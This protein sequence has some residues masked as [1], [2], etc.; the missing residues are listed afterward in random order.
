M[1]IF[2]EWLAEAKQLY[3]HE[4][5]PFAEKNQGSTRAGLRKPVTLQVTDD[6]PQGQYMGAEVIYWSWSPQY[7]FCTID[8]GGRRLIVKGYN[9]SGGPWDHCFL[10]WLGLAEGF[11][12][13][14]VAYGCGRKIQETLKGPISIRSHSMQIPCR[15]SLIHLVLDQGP[16][17]M[18][19]PNNSQSGNHQY[20]L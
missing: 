10:S 14:T 18:A 5:P 12:K 20:Y 7:T 9:W 11:S 8:I 13:R 16:T 17:L 2:I 15:C 6:Q 19:V 1:T 4:L 3:H